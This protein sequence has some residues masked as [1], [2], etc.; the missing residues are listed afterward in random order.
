MYDPQPVQEKDK[1][2]AWRW[3]EEHRAHVDRLV[4]D[5]ELAYP[6]SGSD[7]IRPELWK[8]NHWKWLLKM[9]LAPSRTLV[10]VVEVNDL[11]CKVVLPGFDGA[12]EHIPVL[13]DQI[14]PDIWIL[15]KVDKRLHAKVNIGA[16]CAEDLMFS[17]WERE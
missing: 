3:Y 13:R 6:P 2:C 15:F 17:D 9:T 11:D 1:L 10:R 16:E 4:A 8:P 5:C 14:P 7:C 12:R